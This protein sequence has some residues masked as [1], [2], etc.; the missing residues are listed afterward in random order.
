MVIIFPGLFTAI[1]P[2]PLQA[3]PGLVTVS[4]C[5]C[6]CVC[7]R[8]CVCACVRA[9]VCVNIIIINIVY[10]CMSICIVFVFIAR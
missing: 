5:V 6:V 7:V 4:V 2:T 1:P 8:A 9:C 3:L 10:V